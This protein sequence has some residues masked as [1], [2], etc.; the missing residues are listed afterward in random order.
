MR[1]RV[2]HR[3]IQLFVASLLLAAM[4]ACTGSTDDVSPPASRSATPAAASSTSGFA[5][6]A[7]VASTWT[8]TRC[9]AGSDE[10]L[11]ADVSSMELAPVVRIVD[12][13][14]LH[15][16]FEGHD[17]SVRLYGIDAREVGQP[18]AADATARLRTLAGGSVLLRRDARDRDRYGR[19]LRYVYTPSG[20]SIDAALVREGLAHAWR[21]DGVLRGAIEAVEL[22]AKSSSRGCLWAGM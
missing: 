16:D 21:A 7:P 2:V 11:C 12:G 17:E 10:L 22:Q 8:P 18:C 5:T 4:A 9:A 13:D 1:E 3:L 19:L 20:E 6:G 14:T 15:V